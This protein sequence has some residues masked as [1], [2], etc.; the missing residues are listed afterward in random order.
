MRRLEK[1]E[2]DIEEPMYG[3]SPVISKQPVL[4]KKESVINKSVFENVAVSNSYLQT[5]KR[6][7]E[8]SFLNAP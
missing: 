2:K 8:P 4:M 7:Y 6:M 5:Q 1:N 3:Q